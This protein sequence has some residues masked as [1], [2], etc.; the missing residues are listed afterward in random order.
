MEN[1][2]TL[3]AKY[4]ESA[5]HRQSYFWDS[6]HLRLSFDNFRP[7]INL[8]TLIA[9]MKPPKGHK[10]DEG[11]HEHSE[12]DCDV[13]D[14]AEYHVGKKRRHSDSLHFLRRGVQVVDDDGEL[15]ADNRS[16]SSDGSYEGLSHKQIYPCTWEKGRQQV[17]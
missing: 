10:D 16:S 3:N 15:D 6:H 9:L 4:T 14:E 2:R 12:G 13:D 7:A 5:R 1:I 8:N 11:E 17:Q